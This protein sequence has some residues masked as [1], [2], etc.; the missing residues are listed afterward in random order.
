MGFIMIPGFP[1][2]V[3]TPHYHLWTDAL[4]AR[5]LAHQAANEWD[6]GTYV[7][8][9]VITA[10]IAFEM[11]CEKVLGCRGMG[12]SFRDNLDSAIKSMGHAKLNWG[13]GPWQQ[14]LDV[15]KR[16]KEYV[17]INA[18]QEQLF[19]GVVVADH[20]IET[21]REA[22]RTLHAHVSMSPPEWIE[23]D[24]DP[25]WDSGAGLWGDD[26][27]VARGASADDPQA[28]RIVYVCKGREHVSD[29][30]PA[31]ADPGPAMERLLRGIRIPIT[32]VRAYRGKELICE[33]RLRMRGA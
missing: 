20:A 13:S 23:A 2:S 15:H 29:I 6:R 19:P 7:R 32:C 12:R 22:I 18:R 16:R 14:V 3:E 25:G 27:L 11:T 4:H 30:L 17:H 9:T 21:L 33:Q 24:K 10:W 8:W 26:T 1:K 31:E 5:A 28:V